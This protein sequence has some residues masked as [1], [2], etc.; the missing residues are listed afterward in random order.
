MANL[1][2][3]KD[4]ADKRNI[5]IKRLAELVGVTENQIYTLIRTNTTK[6]GTLE[7]I[8]HILQVPIGCF[9]DIPSVTE[10]FSATGDNNIVAKTIGAVS[11]RGRRPKGT[12][13]TG[14]GSLMEAT[15]IITSQEKE[16]EM[17]KQL[18][19]EKERLIA[20]YER[21]NPSSPSEER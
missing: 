3:I 7:K 16:I 12:P 21:V 6:I 5:S 8:A 9:F 15:Y 11:H 1:H 4:L 13:S 10:T 20:L 19:A 2:I 17:L 14:P 18:L